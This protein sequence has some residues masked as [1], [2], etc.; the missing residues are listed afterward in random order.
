MHGP[1]KPIKC[2]DSNR[3]TPYIA[4]YSS[5]VLVQLFILRSHCRRMRDIKQ[6]LMKSSNQSIIAVVWVVH[7]IPVGAHKF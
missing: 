7:H 3:H 4:S 2:R 5:V 6:Q 1:P